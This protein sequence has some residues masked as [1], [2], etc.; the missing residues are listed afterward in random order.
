MSE[1]RRPSRG[2][3]AKTPAIAPIRRSNRTAHLI[4]ISLRFR[5]QLEP[6]L[7]DERGATPA[8][9]K[10]LRICYWVDLAARRGME[11]AGKDKAVLLRQV[12]VVVA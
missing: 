2:G 11:I 7:C 3:S 5:A 9:C 4:R 1:V 10:T 6:E 12:R 8:R